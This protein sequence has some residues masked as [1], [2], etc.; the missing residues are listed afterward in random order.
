MDTMTDFVLLRPAP[1]SKNRCEGELRS[2]IT[3]ANLV[4]RMLQRA[5]GYRTVMVTLPF[6]VREPEV[7]VT[8]IT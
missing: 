2:K 8:V 7:P 3:N 4:A 5:P 1:R 6:A